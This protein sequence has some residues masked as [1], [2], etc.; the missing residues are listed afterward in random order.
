MREPARV[1]TVPPMVVRCGACRH[2]YDERA[3]QALPLERVIEPSELHRT[4]TRWPADVRIE[5]RRCRGCGRSVSAK[6]RVA[7]R[8]ASAR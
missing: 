4:V 3:W 8:R 2:D 1:L 7:A 5:V 6:R